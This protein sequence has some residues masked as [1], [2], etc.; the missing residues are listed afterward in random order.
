METPFSL[1]PLPIETEFRVESIKQR[2]HQ[3]SRDELEQMLGE[4]LMLLVT[5]THQVKQMRNYI[6]GKTTENN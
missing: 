3:L 2:M 5:M 1:N 4:S 6:E